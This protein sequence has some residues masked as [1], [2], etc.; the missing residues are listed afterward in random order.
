MKTILTVKNSN[1]KEYRVRGF[2]SDV[3][4]NALSHYI[5]DTFETRL[6]ASKQEV[7]GYYY[8]SCAD[9]ENELNSILNILTN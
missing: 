1:N 6:N 5:I 2:K 4:I 9:T 3:A 8:V 7:E